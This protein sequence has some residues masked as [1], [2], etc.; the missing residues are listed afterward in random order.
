MNW[1]HLLRLGTATASL[2]LLLSTGCKPKSLPVSLVDDGGGRKP[3]DFPELA[4]DVFKPMDGGIALTG[5]EVKG[6][7]TWNLWCG[8]D[9]QFWDRMARESYGLIDLLKTIDSRNRG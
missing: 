4:D 2:G 6:R 9:E 7:N 8:G 1:T 3:E 5:D